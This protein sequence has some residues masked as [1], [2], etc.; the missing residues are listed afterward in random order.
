MLNLTP[1]FH[2]RFLSERRRYHTSNYLRP[3]L[4]LFFFYRFINKRDLYVNTDIE[5]FF[6]FFF[7][8]QVLLYV[9]IRE[10]PK[11]KPS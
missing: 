9:E 5:I 11:P 1:Y 7:I 4:D 8:F 6:I 3:F 2:G 10:L